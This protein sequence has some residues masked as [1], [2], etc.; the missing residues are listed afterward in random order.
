[1]PIPK[2]QPSIAAGWRSYREMVMHPQVPDIQ[3]AEC[4][5]AFW[6][7]A[8]TLFYAIMDALDPGE[9]PTAADLQ[10]MENIA[11]EIDKFAS[12]FDAEVLKRHGGRQ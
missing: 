9:E 10:R 8:S 2:K 1:M 11:A 7:G 6:A 5:L 3:V 12:T 4:N